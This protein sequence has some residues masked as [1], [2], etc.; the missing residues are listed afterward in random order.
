MSNEVIKDELLSGSVSFLEDAQFSSENKIFTDK[1]IS[2]ILFA[3]SDVCVLHTEVL[4]GQAHVSG[5][6]I[7]NIT[8]ETAENEFDAASAEMEF[9]EVIKNDKIMQG[10][11]ICVSAKVVD[12]AVQFVSTSEVAV[13][14]VAQ[15]SAKLISNENISFVTGGGDGLYVL[16]DEYS[17]KFLTKSGKEE[18]NFEIE[19]PSRDNALKVL[20]SS[21]CPVLKNIKARE[22]I[23]QVDVAAFYNL[24]VDDAGQLKV[25][26][27]EAQISEEIVLDGA[28]EGSLVCGK[29]HICS[30]MAEQAE[31]KLVLKIG[32]MLCYDIYEEKTLH[33]VSDAFSTTNDINLNVVSAL[34]NRFAYNFSDSTEIVGNITVKDESFE[35]RKV[36]GALPKT[37]IFSKVSMEDVEILIEGIA[38]FT[39]IY[40]GIDDSIESVDVEIPFASKVKNPSDAGAQIVLSGGCTFDVKAK[41]RKANEIEISAGINL[42]FNVFEKNEFAYVSGVEIGEEKMSDDSALT[43]YVVKEGESVFDIAKKLSLDIAELKAQNPELEE[44]L[45]VGA[46]IAFYKQKNLN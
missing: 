12:E 17:D 1:E 13:K 7:S 42:C 11:N 8:F 9:N 14:T 22:G 35:I 18:I 46:R 5:K 37:L 34:Q 31:N 28:G 41:I 24:L 45:Q 20:N 10:D 16:D 23:A 15:L 40:E 38:S 36:I 6:V 27:D 19:I 30:C 4:D 21:C 26:N 3:T 39:A 29:L 44:G 43:V 25:I 2:K 33:F 32:A